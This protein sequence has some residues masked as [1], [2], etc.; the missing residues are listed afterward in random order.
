MVP[1]EELHQANALSQLVVQSTKVVGPALGG[2]LVALTG[3]RPAFAV[4]AAT[5][6]CSAAI[7]SRLSPLVAAGGDEADGEEGPETA[8][9]GFW[10]EFDALSAEEQEALGKLDQSE[11]EALAAIRNKLNDDGAEVSGYAMNKLAGD[12]NLVW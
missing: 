4:D 11:V 10:A 12:G 3:P 6:V 9:A 5:F 8:T 1:E 2:A 7:L